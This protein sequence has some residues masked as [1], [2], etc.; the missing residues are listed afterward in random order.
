MSA[1]IA[2]A[3]VSAAAQCFASPLPAP[4][5]SPALPSTR[6]ALVF[7]THAAF[8]SQ[9]TRRSPAIDPQAFVRDDAAAE[10]TGPQ[11]IAHVA[12]LRTAR[13]DDLPE[14]V[15]YT[16]KRDS[17]GFTVQKWFGANGMVELASGTGGAT[18]ATFSFKKLIA[19][20]VYSLFRINFSP[21]G[22]TFLPF[23]GDGTTNTFT[24][25]VDGTA[26]MVMTS[27]DALPR[28]SAIVLIYHSDAQEHGTSR[29]EIGVS[30]H[31]QLIVRL[32]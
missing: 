19:F 3:F 14:S 7:V 24:A 27:P 28:G 22:A 13:I 10:G 12:G 25:S 29:G 31:H 9:E 4:A 8:F 2:A 32:Q 6:P 18:R 17:L 11:N 26:A 21:D 20:G 1:L 5:A 15:A 16:A 30:A 23:D